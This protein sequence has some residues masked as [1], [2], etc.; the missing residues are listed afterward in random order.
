MRL[1]SSNAR[2]TAIFLLVGWLSLF[3]LHAA[4][5]TVKVVCFGDSITKSVRQKGEL[6][7]P[8]QLAKK[9]QVEVINAGVGG[10]TT[11]AGLARMDKDVLAHKPDGVV[12]L[13][14]TNDSV[15]T[16]PQKYR[17]PLT[18]YK[19]NLLKM[20]ERCR[21]HNARVVLCTI[22][23]INPEPYF[24]RHPQEVYAA[25]GGL[26]HIL[27][28]YR[29]AIMEVG[30][31]Q[32]VPVVDLGGKLNQAAAL[33]PDGVHMTDQGCELIAALVAETLGPELNPGKAAK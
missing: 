22:P 20:V 29:K 11:G 3:R 30:Q 32:H 9:L 6:T 2:G 7:Y 4:D 24:Q 10:N 33:S 21:Q 15:L 27:D 16:G 17:T 5:A 1:I 26:E 18:D 28:R 31:A 13:F 23:P 25:E 8:A 14:G 19:A 12:I